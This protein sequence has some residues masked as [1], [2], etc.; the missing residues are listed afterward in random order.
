MTTSRAAFDR[1]FAFAKSLG[2]EAVAAILAA[3]NDEATNTG[4]ARKVLTDADLA[5]MPAPDDTNDRYDF[6]LPDQTF[7]SVQTTGGAWGKL[8]VC[9]DPDTTT[10]TDADLIPL[11]KHDFVVTPNGG[12]ITAQF[13]TGGFQ[14]AS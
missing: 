11:S 13:A 6:D 4:Y 14:R 10:G 5:A 8:L 3:A 9:Y 12:D 7:T 1:A 2:K